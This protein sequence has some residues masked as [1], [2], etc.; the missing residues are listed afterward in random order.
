MNNKQDDQLLG[1]KEALVDLWARD[2][3]KLLDLGRFKEAEAVA[4]S[5]GFPKQEIK[6][7]IKD[8]V[9]KEEKN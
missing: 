8:C 5:L 7:I 9:F 4:L 6:E 1:I 3:T 2:I